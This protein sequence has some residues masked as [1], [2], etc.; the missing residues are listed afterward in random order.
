MKPLPNRAITC[1]DMRVFYKLS[2]QI[3]LW[4]IET[5][6]TTTRRITGEGE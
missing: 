1:L 5:S 3:M 2:T 6:I 4:C